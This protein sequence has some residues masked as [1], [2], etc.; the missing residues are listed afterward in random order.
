MARRGSVF[1]CRFGEGAAEVGCIEV[2]VV[3]KPSAASGVCQNPSLHLPTTNHFPRRVLERRDGHVPPSVGVARRITF[4]RVLHP[5]DKLGVVG[6]V[7]RPAREVL[8]PRPAF[9]VDARLATQGVDDHPGII[10]KSGEAARQLEEVA[11]LGQRILLEHVVLLEIIFGRSLDNAQRRKIHDV[12]P[13]SGEYLAKLT[14]LARA[15]C[16]EQEPR[17][18]HSGSGSGSGSASAVV[19]AASSEWMPEIARSTSWLSCARSNV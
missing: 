4:Q 18:T 3:T 15:A 11:R 6:I 16:R 19:C 2:R 10:T 14:Q 8:A 1:D 7:E 9:A 13:E 12:Q 17:P 5:R